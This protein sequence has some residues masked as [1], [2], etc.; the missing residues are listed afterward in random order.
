MSKRTALKPRLVVWLCGLLVGLSIAS[1]LAAR[2][3]KVNETVRALSDDNRIGWEDSAAEIESRVEGWES[4]S[5][6]AIGISVTLYLAAAVW[7][8]TRGRH[9]SR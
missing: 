9:Q 2:I 6:V 5:L 3:W 4:G 1:Y 8:V 7:F